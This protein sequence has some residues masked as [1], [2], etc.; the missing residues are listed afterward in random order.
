MSRLDA[1][2]LA[3]ETLE[4]NKF[5]G[6]NNATQFSQIN[7]NQSPRLLNLL[8][9]K[10]LSLENR[11]GTR[12]LTSSAMGAIA[13]YPVYIKAGVKSEL[14]TSGTTLYKYNAATFVYDAQTM[15]ATLATPNIGWEQF[16]DNNSAE[17]V[18]IADG[19]S[20]KS[21]NGT[22]VTNITPAAN[23]TSPLPANTLA[24]INSSNPAVGVTV[25]NNRLVVWPAGK[26]I[27]Y[28]SKPGF[29]DYFPVTSF[30][31]FVR[32]NDT[33]VTCAS[34][35][36]SL[37][38]F[39]KN[40]VGVLFG[41]GYNSPVLSTDWT[42]D[43]L[44]TTEGC[45]NGQSVRMVTFPDLHEEMFYQTYRGVSSV[46]SIDTK[47]QDNSSRVSTR[48]LTDSKVDLAALGVTP[49]Q[50]ASAA[51]Y[52]HDGRYWL[53]WNQGTTGWRGIVFDTRN[54]EW[55]PV[56]NIQAT[57]FSADNAL[58]LFTYT[59]PDGNLR[60]FDGTI[61]QDL[62]NYSGTTGTPVAWEWYSKLLNPDFNGYKHLW[63]I[64][65]IES[66]QFAVP[67]GIDIQVNTLQNKFDE[68]KAVKNSIMI[69]GQSIIGYATIA[70]LS[71]TDFIN[72]GDRIRVFVKGQYAQIKL[73]SDRGEPVA[74]YDIRFE[75]R[76]QA[77]YS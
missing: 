35:A 18:I 14:A 41:D 70:N 40:S 69:I 63:D 52:F 5:A 30:Q 54:Q 46:Y 34:F 74:L 49:A 36:S 51:S 23:D 76:P 73:S 3:S 32:E 8:P 61:Y 17:V 55:Y 71:L 10:T 16:R 12:L 25:H 56:N 15:T 65:I 58:G 9:G 2:G 38:V 47:S 43:F 66:Q 45:V 13:R 4:I 37:L 6:L 75:V 64:L 57:D 48:S 1:R 22:A 31:R 44:D 42:Q 24:T 77:A 39:M 53:V 26:D 68:P 20:L 11:D 29:Y 50:W 19:G 7:I 62:T 67:A 72:N 59:T 27:I 60:I 33:I 21:Y 28:H